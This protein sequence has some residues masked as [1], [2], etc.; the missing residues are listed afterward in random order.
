MVQQ[1][2]SDLEPLF[3]D[4]LEG[5]GEANNRDISGSE[6]YSVVLEAFQ[7]DTPSIVECSVQRRQDRISFRLGYNPSTRT[8]NILVTI[9]DVINAIVPGIT[10]TRAM[11]YIM[12]QL[13]EPDIEN[14]MEAAATRIVR[15][16]FM[17]YY[18]EG[19][20]HKLVYALDDTSNVSEGS[21]QRRTGN[22]LTKPTVAV[23]YVRYSDG[24]FYTHPKGT[25]T[26]DSLGVEIDSTVFY[27]ADYSSKHRRTERE[28]L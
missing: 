27:K 3:D 4:R 21:I 25:G 12:G 23:T 20:V 13:L 26:H 11:S 8:I 18:V 17:N 7:S 5:K 19:L 9:S 22:P 15:D 16:K 28:E 6:L 1:N 24:G 10:Y 14:E 2:T